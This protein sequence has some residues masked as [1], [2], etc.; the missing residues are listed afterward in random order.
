VICE[1]DDPWYKRAPRR[2]GVAERH[3]AG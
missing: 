3:A 2:A 1:P